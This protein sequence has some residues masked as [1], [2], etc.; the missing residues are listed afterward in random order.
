[1]IRS[2]VTGG[3]GFI[4]SHLVEALLARGDQVWAVDDEST[5]ARENL[6]AVADHRRFR[7]TRASVTD[8]RVVEELVSQADEVYH[9]AAAVGVQLAARESVR[10]IRTNVEPTV[11]LLEGLARRHRAGHP[12]KFF[13]A[14]SSEIYGKNP[15]PVWSE[16][17]VAV[18]G[19]VDFPR[20]SYG[21][22]KLLDELLALG[23]HREQGLHV[24][25]ARLF[26]V[27]GPRQTGAYGMVLPRL[28]DAVLSGRP[29]TVYDDGQQ[30]RCF[31]HVSDAVSAITALMSAPDA[32]G[33]AVNVGSD[34]PVTILDLARRVAAA[35]DPR[36]E[37]RFQSYESAY[38]REFEDCRRRVPDLA[39][40]R[41][42]ID[43]R[44]RYSLDRII[45]EVIAWRRRSLSTG[46]GG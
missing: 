6:S 46:P 32:V 19:P 42:T 37:I 40:L 36:L 34:E 10:T 29:P 25:I 20:W 1:M 17:D 43:Y 8:P 16:D 39:R 24:V 22:A 18:L 5:G 13:L 11:L 38:G 9:L 14:S 44:P 21:V 26:N 2:V 4:G 31:A 33:R 3:A 23:Y 12:V 15:R 30:I 7:Y 28:V 27:V 45:A 41:Q 35:V